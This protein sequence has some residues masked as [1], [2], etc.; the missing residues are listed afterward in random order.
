[1]CQKPTFATPRAAYANTSSA[2]PSNASGTVR[3]S[4]LQPAAQASL[5]VFRPSARAQQCRQLDEKHRSLRHLLVCGLHVNLEVKPL[6]ENTRKSNNWWPDMPNEQLGLLDGVIQDRLPR[7]RSCCARAIAMN[8]QQIRGPPDRISPQQADTASDVRRCRG[9][10]S[11]GR[12]GPTVSPHEY[13]E[14]PTPRRTLSCGRASNNALAR[15]VKASG[16][17]GASLITS[18]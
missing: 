2:R 6:A 12:I 11:L 16:T 18:R 13:G 8:L 14:H 4:S 5:Q 15:P 10:S 9:S 17:S 7:R 1:M 3:P